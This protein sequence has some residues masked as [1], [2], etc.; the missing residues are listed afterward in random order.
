LV[1]VVSF[2]EVIMEQSEKVDFN[3]EVN[4]TDIN[5]EELDLITRQLLPESREMDVVTRAGIRPWTL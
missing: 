1:T 3:F 2:L 4:A 5:D